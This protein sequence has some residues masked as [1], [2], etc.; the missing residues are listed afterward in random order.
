[1]KNIFGFSSKVLF[2]V[3]LIVA[4]AVFF[5][6]NF[7]SAAPY[8]Q[9][10]VI[11]GISW[12]KSTLKRTAVG[13]NFP[14]TWAD[15]DNIYT[16]WGD[17]YGFNS[18]WSEDESI[19]QVELGV[20]RISGSPG[21]F[22]AVNVFGG[23][24]YLN[25]ATFGGKSYGILSIG[26]VLYMLQGPLDRDVSGG[27]KPVDG[28]GS[29]WKAASE[30]T[31]GVSYNHGATW[32]RTTNIILSQAD[33]FCSP[34]FLNFGKDYA[35]ARDN[36]VYIYGRDCSGGDGS[37]MQTVEK[38]SLARVPKNSITN[39]SA[40]EF[41]AGTGGSENWV[42]SSANRKP[43]YTNSIG[44]PV[45]GS[46]DAA[47]AIYYPNIGRYL[48]FVTHGTPGSPRGG[49]G[50]YDGPNPWGPWTTVE[51]DDSWMGSDRLFYAN[52]PTK[53][54]SG[55]SFYMVFTGSTQASDAIAN[56]AYQHMKGT[57][58]LASTP[59]P[60]PTPIPSPA[61]SGYTY[62]AIER[63]YCGFS[64]TRNVKYGL[65]SIF[66]TKTFTGGTQCDNATFTDPYPGDLK[67]CY[68]SNTVITPTPTPTAIT[69]PSKPTVSGSCSGGAY[70]ANISWS[71]TPN[72]TY[73]FYIDL[74]TTN[75]FTRPYWIKTVA[76]GT[77]TQGPSGFVVYPTGGNLPALT[78]NPGTY[79]IRIYNGLHS[80]ANSF[81]AP[82]CATPTPTPTSITTLCHLLTSANTTP[83]GYGASY[84]PLT[85]AKELL[86]N[87]LCQSTSAT[88]TI[89]NNSN[90][91]Y[92][93]NKGYIYNPSA[94]SGQGAWQQVTYNCS[95]SNLVSSAWCVGNAN[96]TINLTSTEMA[97]INYILGYICSW[98]GT[99]WQC[100]CRDSS[101]SVNYW[102]LQE[103]KR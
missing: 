4:M 28:N 88:I 39:R 2:V 16:I 26:G 66:V 58:I 96:A 37:T 38:I 18:N 59:T 32:S 83:T 101:C 82:S 22:S 74:A 6:P 86:M 75:S 43:V 64:G 14:T 97:S 99:Q 7:A 46:Y 35:G 53:W 1:M 65:N 95:N 90:Y 10:S 34:G 19:Q 11:S 17:G 36:Y 30:T 31:V 44:Y 50:V 51:Y 89:G 76:S 94:N 27:W 80:P 33:G 87:V 56:Y 69:A 15:D 60:T 70:T 61:P 12:D 100:G 81:T 57:F 54:I 103:F 13:D 85:T 29:G 25:K 48:L 71:G 42:S 41:Y 55:N 5:V 20:A 78:F 91:Q 45:P 52:I 23:K 102:N 63:G 98:S 9:S 3:F 8:P 79:Y 47:S 73:G 40:Y 72:Q 84:N 68:Y 49:L 93:Y 67:Y 92:I 62:C 21:S 77:S 24:N